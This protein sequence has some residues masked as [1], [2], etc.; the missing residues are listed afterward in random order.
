MVPCKGTRKNRVYSF[1]ESEIVFSVFFLRSQR[2]YAGAYTTFDSKMTQ[3]LFGHYFPNKSPKI[4]SQNFEFWILV[5]F[6]LRNIR[7]VIFNFSPF[8]AKESEL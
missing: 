2:C 7:N 5:I 3:G 6:W 4:F 1:A 8:T